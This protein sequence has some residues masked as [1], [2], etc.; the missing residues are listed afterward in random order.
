VLKFCVLFYPIDIACLPFPFYKFPHFL[1]NMF[2]CTVIVVIANCSL[3]NVYTC[4][5]NPSYHHIIY[6]ILFLTVSNG[7]LLSTLIIRNVS[8]AEIQDIRII[9]EDD[10]EA[11]NSAL[12]YR[13]TF[14]HL[15]S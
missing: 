9:S 4:W 12:H 1:K 13:H 2:V 8:R 10:T 6:T 15:K 5:T 14:L 3:I 11:K 7:F